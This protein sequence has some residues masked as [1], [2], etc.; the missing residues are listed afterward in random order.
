MAPGQGRRGALERGL[1]VPEMCSTIMRLLGPMRGC[2]TSSACHR[3]QHR[4][5]LPSAAGRRPK[6][7]PPTLK[8]RTHHAARTVP[9]QHNMGSAARSHRASR[10]HCQPPPALGRDRVSA[11]RDS[12]RTPSEPGARRGSLSMADAARPCR[13]ASRAPSSPP[14]PA[15]HPPRRAPGRSSRCAAGSR[16]RPRRVDAVRRQEAGDALLAPQNAR[17]FSTAASA[18]VVDGQHLPLPIAVDAGVPVIPL[19]A[20]PFRRALIASTS[21]SCSS[22]VRKSAW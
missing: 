11:W 7:M 19:V 15:T 18:V 6:R 22:A 21:A 2:R 13:S 10:N 8:L 9:K 12:S 20:V 14:T 16:R 4:A 17:T 5:T 1:P 3:R